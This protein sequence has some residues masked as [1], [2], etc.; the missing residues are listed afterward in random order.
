MLT[1]AAALLALAVPTP[2]AAPAVDPPAAAVME[3]LHFSGSGCAAGNTN[4]SHSPDRHAAAL[5]YS[6]Y[7]VFVGPDL[8]PS[9]ASKSCTVVL[10]VTPPAGYTSA[11]DLIDQRGAATLPARATG[12][13]RVSYQSANSSPVR[14]D[15]RL[16]VPSEDFWQTLHQVP[17]NRQVYGPCGQP[18]YVVVD[19]QLRVTAPSGVT[20][21]ASVYSTDFSTNHLTWKRC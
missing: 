7:G 21:D 20:A 3:V 14:V 1:N 11:V 8:G 15:E 12:E 4:L 6:E 5:I 10:R 13:V 17:A 18:H 16:A 2:I 9:P 19:T